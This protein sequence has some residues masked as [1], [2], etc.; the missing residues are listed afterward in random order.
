MTTDKGNRI[1]VSDDVLWDL[2]SLALADGIDSRYVELYCDLTTG[3]VDEFLHASRNSWTD[4][5]LGEDEVKITAGRG[6]LEVGDGDNLL[7]DEYAHDFENCFDD[8]AGELPVPEA[9]DP[10]HEP[11]S[12]YYDKE[13]IVRYFCDGRLGEDEEKDLGM[14]REMWLPVLDEAFE[15]AARLKRHGENR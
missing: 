4:C 12:D 13:D 10:E 5:D 6:G 8:L 9:Y 11:L 2:H 7:P 1:S 3:E 14:I 15:R